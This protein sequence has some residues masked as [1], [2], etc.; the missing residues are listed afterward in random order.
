MNNKEVNMK[1][2]EI[3]EKLAQPIPPE[4]IKKKPIFSKNPQTGQ[5]KKSGEVDTINWTN[6]CILLDERCG[7]GSWSWQIND[8]KQIGDRLVMTGTLTIYGEDRTISMSASGSE[9]LS[10]TGFGDPSSNSE[11]M[12]F[13]RAACR[14]GLGRQLYRKDN[15]P[16]SS[17][18]NQNRY[19]SSNRSSSYGSKNNN[20]NSGKTISREEWLKRKAFEQ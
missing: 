20:S 12:C 4:L 10:A 7:K 13:K 8:V 18:G 2:A 14:L 19:Y 15:K 6:T 5:L 17:Y 11:A 1:I 16:S 9:S 3:M